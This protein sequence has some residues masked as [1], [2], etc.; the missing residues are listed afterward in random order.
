MRVKA[1][2]TF[3][4][5][6]WLRLI[7]QWVE[8][9]RDPLQFSTEV[10]A[11]EADFSGSGVFAYKLNWQTVIYVGYADNRLLDDFEDLQPDNRQAFIKLSYA[12][13][14]LE[15]MESGRTGVQ[16]SAPVNG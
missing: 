8:T 4:S 13:R 12:F 6:M 14:S 1:V 11:R 7:G 3:N 10:V 5:R 16:S 2:Y 15:G 9:E